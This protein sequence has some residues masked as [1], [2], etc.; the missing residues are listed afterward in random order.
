MNKKDKERSIAKI[1]RK[2]RWYY[3]RFFQ[4]KKRRLW[5]Y[6]SYR[7]YLRQ[8]GKDAAGIGNDSY[9]LTKEVHPGAGIGDQLASWITGY[10]YAG[11]LGVSYAYSRLYP[12]KWERFMGFSQGEV[13]AATLC[14]KEG[15]R[16]VRLPR[17]DE[18]KP[19]EWDMIGHI[20]D[21]YQG[22]KVVFYLELHQVYT[23]QYG[24]MDDLRDKFNRTHPQEK[25]SL[26]YQ[27]GQFNIAVHIRRGDIER[28]QVT[29]ESQLTKR[30]LDNDYYQAVLDRVLAALSDKD[31]AI[32]I[33]S[34]GKEEEF[35]EFAKY[36]NVHYCMDMPATDSFLHMVRADLL[37]TSKS[38]FSYKPALLSGGIRVCPA[39]F[40]HGY[41][42]EDKWIVVDAQSRD[43]LYSITDRIKKAVDR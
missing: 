31:T 20:M 23:E 16:R 33:F 42:G 30:W 36:R 10:Y 21:S 38:S 6:R 24:V 12:D 35:K 3:L 25:E 8:K 32:Y 7:H 22:K 40:W 5:M 1:K 27:K 39:G 11:K 29:G 9:Y 2:I 13:S 43:S 34:Q 41:P 15:F 26:Q 4:E 17:F 28:G 18:N 14:K 19:D 37:V